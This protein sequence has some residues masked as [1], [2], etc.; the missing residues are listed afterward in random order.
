MM[1]DIQEQFE[2]FEKVNNKYRSIGD[3]FVLLLIVVL[4]VQIGVMGYFITNID[5]AE[6]QEKLVKRSIEVVPVLRDEISDT[7][8]EV[9]PVYAEE[10]KQ[11]V[12]KR[13][14]EFEAKLEK[15]SG[16]FVAGFEKK[17]LPKAEAKIDI[18]SERT[19]AVILEEF[20]ELQDSENTE[21]VVKNLKEALV[22]AFADIFTDKLSKADKIFRGIKEKLDKMHKGNL[23]IE[24]NVEIKLLAVTFQLAGK[25]IAEEISQ[26]ESGN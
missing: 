24:D 15:E 26:M 11:K 7:L 4:F 10:F 21:N 18:L 14:P 6:I 1:K 12:E 19:L 3:V 8:R 16:E 13:M 17:I 20:P 25:R 22:I 2:L 23:Q 9:I 5:T